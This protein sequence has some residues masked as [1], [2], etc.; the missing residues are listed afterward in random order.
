MKFD[1]QKFAEGEGAGEVQ[2]DGK[3]IDTGDKTSADD[4][5]QDNPADDVQAKIDAAVSAQLAKAQAK[6]EAEF[7]RR[8]ELA[9]KEAERLSKLS[10]DERAK[11][12]LENTRRELDAQR[13]EF[14]LEKLKYE[15]SQVVSKRGLPVEFTE[16]LI[17]EDSE[18]TLERIKVFEKKFNK[19]VEDAVTAKLKGKAPQS[20]GKTIDNDTNVSASFMKAI[21]DNQIR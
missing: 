21:L 18:K 1:I 9:K 10:D 3:T 8:E 6:W 4:V 15:T 19:A 20:S 7:K 17:A 2:V 5:K 11:A 16:Y 14:E 13:A 12:E